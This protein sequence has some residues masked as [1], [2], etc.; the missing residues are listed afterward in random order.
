MIASTISQA[1]YKWTPNT[2][3][4]FC[5]PF[6]PIFVNV[7]GSLRV[8]TCP[9]LRLVPEA[10]MR[11][12]NHFCLAAPGPALGVPGSE[13]LANR[14]FLQLRDRLARL[15]PSLSGS[16][17][18]VACGCMQR[19]NSCEAQLHASASQSIAAAVQIALGAAALKLQKFP[20][21]SS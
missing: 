4:A 2:P 19:L 20:C 9:I 3:C 13:T 11:M 8:A 15:R 10:H 17:T 14:I 21:M 12:H 18:R 1:I 7:S 6:G 16:V 5:S